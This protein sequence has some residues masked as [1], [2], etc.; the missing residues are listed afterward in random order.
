MKNFHEM[1]PEWLFE[2]KAFLNRQ[3]SGRG[4][5]HDGNHSFAVIAPMIMKFGTSFYNV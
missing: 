3:S 5:G 2:K 1:A 4:G